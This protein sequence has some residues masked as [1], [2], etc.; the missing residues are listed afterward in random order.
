[1]SIPFTQEYEDLEALEASRVEEK[2]PLI[3][4]KVCTK[5]EVFFIFKF[6]SKWNPSQ[7]SIYTE[8]SFQAFLKLN[9]VG[10]NNSKGINKTVSLPF[11]QEFEAA[12]IRE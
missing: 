11:T 8:I 3:S 2:V 1:M 6:K 9:I 4:N 10:R 5:C 7:V 12:R